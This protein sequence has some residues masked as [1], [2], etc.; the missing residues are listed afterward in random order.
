MFRHSANTASFFLHPYG[1]GDFFALS[2]GGGSGTGQQHQSRDSRASEQHYGQL[3][4][5][6]R[7]RCAL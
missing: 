1:C 4:Y 5:R 7:I 2:G 3:Q 6:Q